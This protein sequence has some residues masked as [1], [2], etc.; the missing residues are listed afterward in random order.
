MRADEFPNLMEGGD[1]Q[2]DL[3]IER[4]AEIL[5]RLGVEG[6]A[7][8]HSE[9]IS[10]GGQRNDFVEA[11]RP[12]RHEVKECGD[13]LESGEIDCLDPKLCSDNLGEGFA[14]DN[15]LLEHDL[16]DWTA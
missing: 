5:E 11:G 3:A 8:G 12:C 10:G 9:D 2:H 15:S 1:H 7:K 14:A 6:V 16:L 13:G 4:E